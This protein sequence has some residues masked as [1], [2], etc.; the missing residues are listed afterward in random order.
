MGTP[1]VCPHDNQ[2][3][4]TQGPYYRQ[5]HPNYFQDGLALPRAFILQDTGCGSHYGLSLNDGI[6]TTARRCHREYTHNG[7]YSSAAVLA[8]SEQELRESGAIAIVDSPNEITFAHVDA[9][10]KQPMS[11]RQRDNVGKA[12][13]APANKRGPVYVP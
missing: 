2:P 5:V 4:T 6:R 8:V 13:I 9:L 1:A 10:Y 3:I 11:R 7:G 12:L